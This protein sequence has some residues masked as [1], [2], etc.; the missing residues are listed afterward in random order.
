MNDEIGYKVYRKLAY[1]YENRIPVHFKLI[2]GIWKNGIIL[3]LNV[4]KLIL[5]LREFVE[6][7]QPFLL[8]EIREDSIMRF[9]EKGGENEM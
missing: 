5:I 1:F 6:G 4:N 3:E 8:E 7:E 2:N 9:R